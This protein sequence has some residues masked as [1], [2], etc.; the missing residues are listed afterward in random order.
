MTNK[1]RSV[2]DECCTF[3][4]GS[5]LVKIY[6]WR[7]SEKIDNNYY[8]VDYSTWERDEVRVEHIYHTK[9]EAKQRL[10]DYVQKL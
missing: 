6:N 3:Y 7:I 9:E 2:G 1:E 4:T 5:F 10:I 8:R